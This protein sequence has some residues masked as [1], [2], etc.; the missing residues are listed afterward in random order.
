MEHLAAIEYHNDIF[1]LY[2]YHDTTDDKL[3][4]TTLLIDEIAKEVDFNSKSELLGALM[5]REELAIMKSYGSYKSYL[6]ETDSEYPTYT[7]ALKAMCKS[8]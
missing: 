5:S 2:V 3:L 8:A 6:L 4:F 7:E 1:H